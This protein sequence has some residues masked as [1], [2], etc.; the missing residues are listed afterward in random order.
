M[1][2]DRRLNAFGRLV[3]KQQFGAGQNRAADRQLLLLSS[4]QHAAGAVENLCE[5]GKE[6]VDLV[7]R[8][9]LGHISA[10]LGAIP[11][12][13]EQI[14]LDSQVRDNLPPLRHIGQPALGSDIGLP[15]CNI[16]AVKR[17]GAAFDRKQTRQG[18]QRR[19]LADPV[20]TH[21]AHYFAWIDREGHIPQNVALPII[22]IDVFQLQ[23]HSIWFPSPISGSY[24]AL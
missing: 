9:L 3:Q 1:V 13:E 6:L 17:D 5:F 24:G 22:R 11:I 14:L 12:P 23:H 10:D 18:L 21:E 20:P 7:E 8:V 16:G 4:A 19:G 15:V 2:H